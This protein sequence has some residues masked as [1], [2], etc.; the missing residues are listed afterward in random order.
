[1]A[2]VLNSIGSSREHILLIDYTDPN[3]LTSQLD[4][5]YY[6]LWSEDTREKDF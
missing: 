4:V 2:T 5:T 1:M 6:C 3:V